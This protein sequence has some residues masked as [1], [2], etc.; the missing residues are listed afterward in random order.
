MLNFFTVHKVICTLNTGLGRLKKLNALT[1]SFTQDWKLST[2][3]YEIIENQGERK[4]KKKSNT[5]TKQKT[6]TI[7][8]LEF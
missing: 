1:V 6:G 5:K 3:S 2:N 8:K 7:L 4:R